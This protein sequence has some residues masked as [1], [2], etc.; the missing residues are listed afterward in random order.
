MELCKWELDSWD[1]L[2]KESIASSPSS[3]FREMDQRCPR[4]NRPT[5]INVAKFQASPTRDS[6][7][8]PPRFSHPHSLRSE[9]GKTSEKSFRKEKK[10]QRRLDHEQ[11]WKGF[12]PA[13]GI[14]AP[15]VTSTA[16]KDLSH[17]TCFNS[18]KK[19]YYATK[20]LKPR[21]DRDI[22]ED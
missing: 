2:V 8:K 20:C 1:A 19:A 15:N 16:R 10:K 11:A 4:S 18:D 14:H 5:Y 13:I 3:F 17:L 12:T 9:S 21:K 7:D 6:G 22:S